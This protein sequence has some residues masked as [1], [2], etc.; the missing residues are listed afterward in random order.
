MLRVT[1]VGYPLAVS[2][3]SISTSPDDVRS[4]YKRGPGPNLHEQ[5]N[6][7]LLGLGSTVRRPRGTEKHNLQNYWTASSCLKRIKQL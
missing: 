7:V 6:A 1:F 2:I 4:R 3:E 5:Y